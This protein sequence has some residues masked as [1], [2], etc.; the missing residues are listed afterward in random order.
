MLRLQ[1]N[2]TAFF[3]SFFVALSSLTSVSASANQ[4][5][6]SYVDRINRHYQVENAHRAITEDLYLG[7]VVEAKRFSENGN[8]NELFKVVVY[9]P[10]TGRHREAFFKPRAFGDGGGWNRV[11]ME[12]VAYRLN[13]WLG[14][15]YVPPVAYRRNIMINGQMY[16]EGA[17]IFAV[18]GLRTLNEIQGS[19]M[20]HLSKEAVLSDNRIMSVLLQ[21]PDAHEKNIGVGKHW[22]DGQSEP[23]FLDFGASGKAGGGARMDHYDAWGN[24]QPVTRIRESTLHHLR[25]LNSDTHG[26]VAE[27]MSW[28]EYRR[29][30][31]T[32]DGILHYFE[33]LMRSRG[34]ENVVIFE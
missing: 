11:T 15:D 12:Y 29:M 34:Y 33:N 3:L 24:S 16:H 20:G 2:I 1:K 19:R 4:C 21:N 18:P 10:K 9:N 22:A 13:R 25:R 6:V 17:L 8:R 23:L 7:H 31:Q 26:E 14:M 28:D 5:Q 30:L 27:F 32:R